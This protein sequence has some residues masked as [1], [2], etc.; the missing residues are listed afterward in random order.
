MWAY[1]VDELLCPT[2]DSTVFPQLSTLENL[3][4]GRRVLLER[5]KVH[6]EHWVQLTS[7]MEMQ[8]KHYPRCARHYSLCCPQDTAS[9]ESW[10]QCLSSGFMTADL[11]KVSKWLSS[12]FILPN[13]PHWWKVSTF[14]V[15]LRTFKELCKFLPVNDLFFFNDSSMLF[16]RICVRV[17]SQPQALATITTNFCPLIEEVINLT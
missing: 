10:T 5:W 3:P 16:A 4:A 9:E 8:P 13:F 1:G 7:S 17:E 15:L 12:V 14:E 2:W 11:N 6:W